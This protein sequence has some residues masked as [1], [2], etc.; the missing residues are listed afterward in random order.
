MITQ[1]HHP[2][3]SSSGGPLYLGLVE[4][5]TADR[6]ITLVPHM[7]GLE[8]ICGQRVSKTR[9]GDWRA[10]IS[11]ATCQPCK[12]EALRLSQVSG[13]RKSRL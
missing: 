4:P 8:A 9:N 1:S 10:V 12:V 3:D 5:A 2:I 6:H 7:P 13:F 11:M